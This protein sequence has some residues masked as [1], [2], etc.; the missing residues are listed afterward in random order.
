[1]THKISLAQLKDIATNKPPGYYETVL[2]AGRVEDDVLFLEGDVYDK[3]KKQYSPGLPSLT[4][5]VHNIFG[6]AGKAIKNP[7]P[8]STEERER[9]LAICHACEFLV[10]G[11]R[12][13]KCGCHVNWKARLAAWHCPI[14][15]W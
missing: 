13:L 7:T 12:C 11:K 14:D 3:L 2:Q 4:K 9:R 10:D 8:V 15:K 5:Q 1:M 6:A